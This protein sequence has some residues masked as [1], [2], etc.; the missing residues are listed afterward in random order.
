[1]W[2]FNHSY[3][4]MVVHFFRLRDSDLLLTGVESLGADIF[5]LLGDPRILDLLLVSTTSS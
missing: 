4:S 5:P 1:M 2:G 3:L